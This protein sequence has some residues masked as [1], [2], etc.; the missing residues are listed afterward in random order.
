MAESNDVDKVAVLERGQ[1]QL[2]T[3]IGHTL[4][5][6]LYCPLIIIII[7]TDPVGGEAKERTFTSATIT[8]H[9]NGINQ[10]CNWPVHSKVH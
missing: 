2:E 6:M 5:R 7:I 9:Y 3:M 4:T 1:R 8:V 10:H